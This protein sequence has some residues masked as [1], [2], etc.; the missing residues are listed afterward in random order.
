M[1]GLAFG[2]ALALLTLK[3]NA[4]SQPLA[5]RYECTKLNGGD[6]H[7]KRASGRYQAR[8]IAGQL[9]RLTLRAEKFDS[10]QME[11][12]QCANPNWERLQRSA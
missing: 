1:T 3:A 8:V 7:T 6:R 12:I 4:T 9:R 11:R 5:A 2:T 10:G